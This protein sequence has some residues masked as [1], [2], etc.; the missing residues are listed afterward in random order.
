M[1]KH[2]M[3]NVNGSIMYSLTKTIGPV[4]SNQKSKFTI[5]TSCE[6]LMMEMKRNISVKRKEALKKKRADEK[7]ALKFNN[8]KKKRKK[9]VPGVSVITLYLCI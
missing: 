2:W 6:K 4:S 7:R 3:Y 8:D 1:S 9:I 5:C